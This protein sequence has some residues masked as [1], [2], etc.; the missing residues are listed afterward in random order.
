MFPLHLKMLRPVL[1]ITTCKQQY[2]PGCSHVDIKNKPNGR[3]HPRNNPH[4]TV[5]IPRIGIN[6]A[7]LREVAGTKR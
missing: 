1:A 6:W 5:I 3:Y 7:S 2:K 4:G